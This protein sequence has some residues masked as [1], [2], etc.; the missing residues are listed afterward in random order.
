MI[1]KST[2]L[3]A[4]AEKSSL[5]ILLFLLVCNIL[6]GQNDAKNCFES[7]A[8]Y[9][10]EQHDELEI[11]TKKYN[12]NYSQNAN[13]RGKINIPVVVHI[14]YPTENE[15]ISDA[16]VFS[17][18]DA[19]NRD[20][21][22][23]NNNLD[24]VH[25]DFENIIGQV[26]F[27]FCLATIDP[28][29]QPTVGITRTKAKEN[30]EYSR[31]AKGIYHT[32]DGGQTAWDTNQYLNIWVTKTGSNIAGFGSKPNQNQPDEDGVI[33]SVDYFGQLG[34]ALPDFRLGR[35]GT[36]EVAHYFN[37]F[38]TWDNICGHNDFV[39]DTPIQLSSYS[40]CPNIDE[41]SCGSRDITANFMNYSEDA[42]LAMFTLGQTRRMQAAL[43]FARSGLINSNSCNDPSSV[44]TN[45]DIKVYPNPASYYFCIEVGNIPLEQ[46][47]YT[48]F[49]A[50]GAKME[51]GI[52][53]S[54][55]LQHFPTY[56][57]GVYFIQF[58][59]G[60]EELMVKKI[61]IAN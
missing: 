4:F 1:K 27:N 59:N 15:N 54:N 18:I 44:I 24:S 14:V 40:G 10:Q 41:S 48:I 21:N 19:L 39:A 43:I 30:F 56:R 22:R 3:S 8:Y 61:I 26:G 31:G 45:S 50:Q 33:I 57:N 5:F 2:Y 49:N 38:H 37:L 12:S 46:I 34:T 23:A 32:A 13:S 53:L 6:N 29:G 25:P 17:Q 60:R 47:P 36:H 58:M 28:T 35:T 42:C 16:Q 52:A 55:S 9:D 51:E 11:F 7:N 20:F